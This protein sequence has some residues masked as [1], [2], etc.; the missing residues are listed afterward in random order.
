MFKRIIKFFKQ[1][2]QAKDSADTREGI[3]DF[4]FNKIIELER[5]PDMDTIGRKDFI[6]VRYNQNSYWALFKCPCN[7]GTVISLP[8]QNGHNPRWTLKVS[9]FGRPTL[10]PSIWQNKGCFSHFWITDGKVEVCANTGIE[11]WKA[12]PLKYLNIYKT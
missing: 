9:E 8:L 4:Y 7:C 3:E 6:F 5:T 11:P 12:E 2:F 1:L 10:Y